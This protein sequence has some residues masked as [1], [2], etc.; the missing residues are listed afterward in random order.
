MWI[1][2]VDDC[3]GIYIE[4]MLVGWVLY[5]WVYLIYDEMLECVF[6]DVVE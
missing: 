5:E 6:G 4:L 2:C 3:C 1:F